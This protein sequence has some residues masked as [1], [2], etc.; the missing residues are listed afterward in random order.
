MSQL[1]ENCDETL[2]RPVVTVINDSNSNV[3]RENEDVVKAKEVSNI[4]VLQNAKLIVPIYN[5]SNVT[6]NKSS[7][8]KISSNKKFSEPKKQTP[9]AREC[10]TK[11]FSKIKLDEAQKYPIV[12]K[13][14]V[15]LE[16]VVS[17]TVQAPPRK[18]KP[19]KKVYEDFSVPP[20]QIQEDML[21]SAVEVAK[22]V[23]QVEEDTE[24][25]LTK[26]DSIED[27]SVDVTHDKFSLDLKFPSLEPLDPLDNFVDTF[28]K[29]PTETTE[30]AKE[31]LF[32]VDPPKGVW[33]NMNHKKLIFAMCSSLKD[34]PSNTENPSNPVETHESQDSDYKSLD[35]E[36]CTKAIETEGDSE[37]SPRSDDTTTSGSDDNTEENSGVLSDR[38]KQQ[39]ED[40][41]EELRPLIKNS[42]KN[43]DSS[44]H[45]DTP[46]T[47]LSCNVNDVSSMQNTPTHVANSNK[48][49]PRKKRR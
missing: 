36:E 23:V 1:H 46:S 12:E 40:D 20:F 10:V 34:T 17:S 5:E 45:D 14:P 30:S 33:N 49:K 15:V 11:D 3:C 7:S 43:N 4:N 42:F 21:K 6:R 39:Q 16:S 47:D 32:S 28:D 22:K 8:S 18:E 27:I 26:S 48:R 13:K 29:R 31:D 9:L 35:A 24:I 25:L 37:E 19:K 44:K 38:A 41:D 2:F